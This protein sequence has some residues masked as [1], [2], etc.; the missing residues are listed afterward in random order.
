M[1]KFFFF[2]SLLA[3]S[4][5]S[6]CQPITTSDTTVKIDYLKRS[7]AQTKTSLVFLGGGAALFAA[8]III[9]N[10]SKSTGLDFTPALGAGGFLCVIGAIAIVSSVPL[11]IFSRINKGRAMNTS[12]SLKF[13]NAPAIQ[14]YKMVHTSYPALSVKI[15]LR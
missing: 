13:E 14:G 8:G 3:V 10:H 11:F 4:A 12:A 1:K 7:K 15:N 5:T 6:F 9:D 2:L